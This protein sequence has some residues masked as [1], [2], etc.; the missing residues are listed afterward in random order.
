LSVGIPQIDEDHKRFSRLVNELNRSI[1]DRAELIEVRRRLQLIIDDAGQHFAHEERLFK[2]W[3]YPDSESHAALHAQI[4]NALQ[5]ILAGIDYPH[6]DKQ[7]ISAGLQTKA[8][9]IDHILK[10][11]A[12]YTKSYLNH[13]GPLPLS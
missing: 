5:N 4:I 11:D 7:W 10:D 1:V 2:D 13:R 12:K 6:Q 8:V 9:L 3:M